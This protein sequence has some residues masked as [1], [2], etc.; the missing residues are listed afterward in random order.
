VEKGFNIRYSVEY[1]R[2]KPQQICN[3]SATGSQHFAGDE[4]M[5]TISREHPQG[6]NVALKV[7][8]GVM[9]ASLNTL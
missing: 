6:G 2:L 9:Q 4:L 8:L 5:M 3:K 1:E 7:I